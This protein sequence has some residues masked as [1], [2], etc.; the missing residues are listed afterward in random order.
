[1][2]T[3]PTV[4][5]LSALCLDSAT[6]T[7]GLTLNPCMLKHTMKLKKSVKICYAANLGFLSYRLDAQAETLSYLC[8]RTENILNTCFTRASQA[9]CCYYE[10]SRISSMKNSLVVTLCLLQTLPNC[11][12]EA[13]LL[14]VHHTW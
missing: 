14:S 8:N 12:T 13:K 9:E 1:M 4:T 7:D 6:T 11:R 2:V 5:A 10:K 3:R